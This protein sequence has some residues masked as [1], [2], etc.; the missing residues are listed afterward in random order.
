MT[1]PKTKEKAVAGDECNIHVSYMHMRS[2]GEGFFASHN[3]HIT[4]WDIPHFTI[5]EASEC[6]TN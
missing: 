5:A 1:S 3:L 4:D 2:M 6:C